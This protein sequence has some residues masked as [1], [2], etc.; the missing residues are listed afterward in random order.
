M[1]MLSSAQLVELKLAASSSARCERLTKLPA[2]LTVAQWALESGWG[3]H[4]PGNNCFGIK[5]Y[6]G[7]FGIQSLSTC[8]V[9]NGVRVSVKQDFAVFPSLD[10]CFE[11]H[12]NLLTTGKPYVRAWLEYLKSPDLNVLV[13]RIAPIYST[14]PNYA[15]ALMSIIGMAMVQASLAE[16]RRAAA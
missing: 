12:A 11:K 10:A 2:D 16:S 4:Q 13:R 5:A 7:C 8:E 6:R 1:S 3:T 14:A 9:V 15:N